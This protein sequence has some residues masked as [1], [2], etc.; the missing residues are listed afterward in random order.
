VISSEPARRPTINDVARRAGVS[1]SLV[2]LVM[3]DSDMVSQARREAVLKA[4]RE[5]GYRP[6]AIARSLAEART[7]T[8]GVIVSDLRSGWP[9]AA[10]RT[11]GRRGFRGRGSARGPSRLLLRRARR[12]RRLPQLPAQVGAGLVAA[13]E[14]DLLRAEP[15]GCQHCHEPDGTVADAGP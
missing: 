13:H 5:L 8:V 3:L 15:S 11:Q 14:D 2:S 6:N 12:R 7:R 4:A 9:T 1:K 10:R